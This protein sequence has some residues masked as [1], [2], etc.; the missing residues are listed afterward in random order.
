MLISSSQWGL[1]TND[2]TIEKQLTPNLWPKKMENPLSKGFLLKFLL[3]FRNRVLQAVLHVDSH[4]LYKRSTN[5]SHFACFEIRFTIVL[6]LR[7]KGKLHV[8]FPH[9]MWYTADPPWICL[10][11]GNPGTN[12]IWGIFYTQFRKLYFL[13][14][15][16]L[17]LILHWI[18]R[19]S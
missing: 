12:S 1:G 11:Q 4:R 10:P 16:S 9:C 6:W 2:R 7:L 19:F 14:S 18:S 15:G 3:N 5:W 13:I 17:K 8:W